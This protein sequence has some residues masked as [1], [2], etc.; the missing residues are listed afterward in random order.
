VAGVVGANLSA[1][2]MHPSISNLDIRALHGSPGD[3]MRRFFL[4][5]FPGVSSVRM[6]ERLAID[7]LRVVWQV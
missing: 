2:P 3:P 4:P 1:L 5:V 6:V 7:I